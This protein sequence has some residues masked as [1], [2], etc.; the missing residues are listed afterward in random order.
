MATNL[1]REQLGVE[2][3]AH[4]VAHVAESGTPDAKALTYQ[5]DLVLALREGDRTACAMVVE[6]QLRVD[7]RK[8][9]TWPHYL[10]AVG[11]ELDCPAIVVVVTPDA[12][13][14]EWAAAPIALGPGHNVVTPF[15]LGPRIIPRVD[16]TT[17]RTHPELAVLSALAHRDDPGGFEVAW[18]AL[19]GVASLDE[20]VAQRYTNFVMSMLSKAAQAQMR[21]R[22]GAMENIEI[23]DFVQQWKDEARAAGLE[24]G[25][26]A[27]RRALLSRQLQLRFGA[28]SPETV[29]EIAEGNPEQ[30]ERWAE[31][32]ITADTLDGVF[33]D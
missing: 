18:A 3:P 20:D 31:R 4:T 19:R 16:E 28:L 24:E 13:V 23:I 25:L 8:K 11:A 10:P 33:A 21:Q 6:V 9:R 15:V 26:A 32:V 12:K 2:L 14:Q 17:A 30:L 5:A 7:P 1:V 29:A 22:T 27:G